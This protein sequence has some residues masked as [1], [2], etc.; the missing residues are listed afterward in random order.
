MMLIAEIASDLTVMAPYVQWGFAGFCFVVFVTLTT[1]NVWLMKNYITVVKENNVVIAGNT[2]AITAVHN[3]ADAT[4]VLMG[5][6]R[7]QLLSRPCMM[8]HK[9]QQ[10]MAKTSQIK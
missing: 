8:G 7:D 2:A 10:E 3:T 1:I 6:I 4:K 9:Q 5:D